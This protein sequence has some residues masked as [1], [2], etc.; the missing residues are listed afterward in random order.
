MEPRL[1]KVEL[2]PHERAAIRAKFY[3]DDQVRAQLDAHSASSDV[4]TILFST[5][6]V[7]FLA[8]DLTH[9]IVKC[10]CRDPSIIDLSDRF[11]YIDA[12]GDGS[13]DCWY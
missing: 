5:V 2:W 6:D 10:D 7:H 4:E 3:V 12:T 8:G 13:L 11:D 9:A 1:I